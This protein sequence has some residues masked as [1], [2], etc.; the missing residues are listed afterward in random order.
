MLIYY[1][2][3][4]FKPKKIR[5]ISIVV[6]LVRTLD[7]DTQVLALDLSQLGELSANVGQ[8]A[9]SHGLVQDLWQDVNA[10]VEL[11][12]LEFWELL[13]ESSV[14]SL[15]QGDLSQNL[16]GERTR[17]DK[18]CV[19]GGTSQVD[20]STL[21]QQDHMTARLHQ[22]TVDLWLD[23]DNVLSV[24]LQ[25]GNVDFDVKVA[26]VANNG[27]I[28]HLG[29]VISC[30][31]VSASGGC[32]KHLTDFAC[33]AHWDNL[34]SFNSSLQ[35]VDWINLG[36]QNTRSHTSQSHG[37]SF[38]D[39]TETGNNGNLTGQHDVGGT[40]DSVDE[41]LTASVQVVKLGLGD[42][43]VHVDGWHLQR[44][45]L[46]HLVQVVDTGGGFLGKTETAF[47]HF[48]VLFVNEGSQISTVIQDQVQFLAVLEG[49]QL[50]LNTPQVLLL[51][52]TLPG[53]NWHTGGG[54]GSSSVVLSGENVTRRPGNLSS[55]SNQSLDENSGL[56]GHVKTSSNSGTL[57]R[58]SRTVLSSDLHQTRHFIFGK[59][60]FLSA[61]R[62]ER[63]VSDLVV[64]HVC[65]GGT[66]MVVTRLYRKIFISF[67]G[68]GR[69]RHVH[70]ACVPGK[71]RGVPASFPEIT[72]EVQG[73][74]SERPVFSHVHAKRCR[75]S[76]I[77]MYF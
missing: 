10:Q 48:R 38:S 12:G 6:R 28:W 65:C 20:Q 32:D 22:V 51:G 69:P 19:S 27:V 17:H 47:K 23:V 63:D 46:Y 41:G 25:P 72:C 16:V 13:F 71:F 67:L 18:R 53:E 45:I 70:S 35:S 76:L 73:C 9:S 44:A 3:D 49:E 50:L 55:K 30:D 26:N 36:D 5:L 11:F 42:T 1:A 43:V 60:N 15:E 77:E 68:C 74:A 66:M 39:I 24:G 34:V 37:T 33:L 64:R 31:D 62:S 61:K 57:Q 40:L 4:A 58:L 52:L 54:N 59:L 7:W 75:R 8:V 21:G 2:V 14:I 29:K 56:N